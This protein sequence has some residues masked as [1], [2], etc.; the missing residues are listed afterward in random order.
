MKGTVN[1]LK[2]KMKI[3]VLAAVMLAV[4]SLRAQDTH[5]SQFYSTPMLVNPAMTGIF[6]GTF[7]LTNTYRSQWGSIADAYKTIHISMD[8]PI[9][10]SRLK[11]NFFGLG[12]MFY[13]DNAGASQFTHT[14]I[15][16]SLAYTTTVDDGDNYIAVGFRGGLDSR[17][18]D[19]TKSTWDSQWNTNDYDPTLPSGEVIQLQQR[20]YF[21]F[22]AGLMWYY[23]P[24]GNNTICVGGSYAHL[25]EPDLSFYTNQV[26]MLNSRI[27]AHGSAEI[28]M[29]EANT[30]WIAPKA[31]V[32]IQGNQQEILAG[33]FVKNKIQLKSKYTNYHRD[34]YVSY[35][36][37]YRFGDAIILATRFDYYEFG[38][39]F[40]FDM[41][42]SQLGSLTSHSAGPEITLSYVSSIKRGQRNKHYNKMPKFF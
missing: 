14:I 28:S 25:T 6:D 4:G 32:Q 8:I 36:A 30:V 24:D 11:K 3:S 27:T 20:T 21:D 33:T 17:Q 39:G 7:R 16:G 42:T 38:L 29:D 2:K 1:N 19:L 34:V 41:N 26:D 15:E 35:G 10:K 40:S 13:Q 12:L 37:W 9:A 31:L 5:F 18:I 23:I 22:T